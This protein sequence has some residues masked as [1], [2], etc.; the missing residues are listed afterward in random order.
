MFAKFRKMGN[1]SSVDEGVAKEALQMLKKRGGR[2]FKCGSGG[3]NY[4]AV[5]DRGALKS[6]LPVLCGLVYAPSSCLA[7]TPLL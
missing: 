1:G 2:I 6:T 7:L 3:E 4:Q 5:D